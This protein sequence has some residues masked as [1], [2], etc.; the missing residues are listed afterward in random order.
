[1]SIARKIITGDAGGDDPYYPWV[2]NPFPEGHP[3]Y[4]SVVLASEFEGTLKD[5]ITGNDL[6]DTKPCHTFIDAGPVWENTKQAVSFTTSGRLA[7]TA[8]VPINNF[9]FSAWVFIKPSPVNT[10]FRFIGDS[11]SAGTVF[12]QH[13][14]LTLQ[15]ALSS[16]TFI[17]VPGSKV[18]EWNYIVVSAEPTGRTYSVNCSTTSDYNPTYQTQ[19][20]VG[21]PYN[22]PISYIGYNGQKSP[23]DVRQFRLYDAPIAESDLAYLHEA[24]WAIP[25][26][27]DGPDGPSDPDFPYV[28]LL[29]N[30]DGNNGANN[31]TF[32]DS[33]SNNFAVN[34]GG[35]VYQGSFSPYATSKPLNM[36]TDGGSVYF[37][38]SDN[39]NLS[40]S[41]STAFDFSTGD[42]TVEC[43]FYQLAQGTSNH[44]ILAAAAGRNVYFALGSGLSG[45]LSMYSGNPAAIYSGPSSMP[46]LNQWNHLVWQ[47]RGGRAQMY[48][49]GTRVYDAVYSADFGT[50]ASGFRVGSSSY[51]TS[52][53]IANGYISDFRVV[54]GTGV[55]DGATITV[56]T[57][58]LGL[59][60]G[61]E[62][63]LKG[64]DAGIYDYT[65]I[66]N[67][68]TVGNAQIDTA[69]K[70]Y[71]TG[72]I[73]F[74][75]TGD[76]LFINRTTALDIGAGDFTVEAWVYATSANK[77][78]QFRRILATEANGS[79][80]VQLYISASGKIVYTANDDAS[81]LTGTTN[82]LNGWHHVAVVREGSAS[83]NIELYVDGSSEGSFTDTASKTSRSFHIGKYPGA[84]GYFQGYL[85]DLRITKGIARYTANFTPPTEA[86]PTY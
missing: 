18:N 77:D 45:G 70:K 5:D 84:S 56:P 71:G 78:G 72:S 35:D 74:D 69:V 36:T 15:I 24:D 63:L 83:G 50:D 86:L 40:V 31:D 22:G 52:S 51:Y 12:M 9:S 81:R 66:N 65:G 62:L 46:A 39:V 8:S 61:T 80:A 10:L 26:D 68:D 28:S 14:G 73:K 34:V 67:L 1:M 64:T 57:S 17:N 13:T 79:S 44:T 85:D 82:V 38:G 21:T 75:G 49:N 41:D 3:K 37:D 29:L 2:V 54:K 53:Y 16:L 42:F 43:F 32:T 48:V 59:T 6:L 47:R 20:S 4:N 19:G 11:N 23:F 55:Y 58:P 27:T 76:Y 25:S 60:S 33:S 30:G 7:L